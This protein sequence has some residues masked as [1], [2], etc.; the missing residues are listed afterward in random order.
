MPLMTSEYAREHQAVTR[1]NP[2]V[3]VL[4]A[5]VPPPRLAAIGRLADV[6]RTDA[7]GLA[8]ALPGAEV[9][10]L[11]DFRSD[12]V[13][14]AWPHADALRWVHI[15]SAG[16]DRLLF[17]GLVESDVVV[18]N[19]RG[20]FDEPIAEYVLGLILCFAKDLHTT[21]RLQDRREWRHRDAERIGGARVLVVGTG[22][23]GRAIG[24]RLSAVGMA[25]SGIGR[26]GRTSD[27][28]LGDIRPFGEL[29]SELGD[30]DYVVLA[31]PLTD[32]TRDMIDAAA[33]ARM[34]PSAR[35][36]NV[37]RGGLVVEKA[38]VDALSE[39]RIA[40][41]A[42]DV[43]A[44]EPL[45]ESSPLWTLPNVLI[46]PHMAGDTV[47]WHDELA[48]LFLDNLGRYRDG[49]PLVNVVDKKLGYVTRGT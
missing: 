42:L 25:V 29:A 3:L 24:R 47:G 31:A 18:T 48:E 27:P 16:V 12:A 39:G 19:S 34:R 7:A 45:P 9:L 40:G 2:A 15:A 41:A 14:A 22:P 44:T 28:D 43:F 36:I 37:G 32:L 13:A 17:P 1:P 6:R 21:V 11:W 38:L 8:E 5:D 35:L 20:V 49:R 30:A 23:I 26:S 33:L 4:E 46:S 10:F